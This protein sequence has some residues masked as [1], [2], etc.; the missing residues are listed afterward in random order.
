MSTISP[1]AEASAAAT[2]STVWGTTT[3]GASLRPREARRAAITSPPLAIRLSL[4]PGV[5]VRISVALPGRN[6]STRSVPAARAARARATAELA[7][8]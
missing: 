7:T 3:G 4:R 8:A 2:A 6:G 1:S 5:R